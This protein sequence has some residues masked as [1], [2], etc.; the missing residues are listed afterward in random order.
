[1]L[2]L[3]NLRCPEYEGRLYLQKVQADLT[4]TS[5]MLLILPRLAC[6]MDT[7][8]LRMIRNIEEVGVKSAWTF[9]R[10]NLPS[11]SGH[12]FAD[13][14][15]TGTKDRILK[16]NFCTDTSH[17]SQ[18]EGCV[19]CVGTEVWF[20]NTVLSPSQLEVGECHPNF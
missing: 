2:E 19:G 16:L 6:I 5:S 12:T 10:Y 1:M 9:C 3:S 7:S 11:Y 17:T 20:R 15:L 18:K 14:Q 13:F 4:P 8:N